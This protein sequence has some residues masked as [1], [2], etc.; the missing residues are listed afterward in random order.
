MCARLG[1]DLKTVHRS[2]RAASPDDLHGPRRT[3]LDPYKADRAGARTSS[4]VRLT[5]ILAQEIELKS[6][7][8]EAEAASTPPGD[9]QVEVA[10][11]GL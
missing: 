8:P 10:E 3:S 7:D 2:L 9:R 5:S 4:S 6:G 1:L 11:A